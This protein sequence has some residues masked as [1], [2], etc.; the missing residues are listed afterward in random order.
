[1]SQ[2]GKVVASREPAAPAAFDPDDGCLKWEVGAMG[3]RE[4]LLS[5]RKRYLAIQ[6]RISDEVA[7]AVIE[8][9][10]QEI[11]E[12]LTQIEK[13]LPDQKSVQPISP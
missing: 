12:R 13:N 8:E 4:R 2:S 3:E 10:I 1:M 7:V 11:E 5:K 6:D 9:L